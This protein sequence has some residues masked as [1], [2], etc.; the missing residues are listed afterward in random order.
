[1]RS[2]LNELV[3]FG[4]CGDERNLV[5][6]GHAATGLNRAEIENAFARGSTKSAWLEGLH[7]PTFMKAD[8]KILSGPNL[9]YAF[10][11]QTFS[12]SAAISDLGNLGN[13]PVAGKIESFRIGVSYA[14]NTLW[15]GPTNKFEMFADEIRRVIRQLKGPP[16][17]D[18]QALELER[19]EPPRFDLSLFRFPLK[20]YSSS[21][22]CS[23][24]K[25]SFRHSLSRVWS[26]A[27][28][29]I[30]ISCGVFVNEP[31]TERWDSAIARLNLSAARTPDRPRWRIAH[32]R[33]A[34]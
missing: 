22:S 15:T 20:S 21:S 11:D 33:A 13:R 6:V 10:G 7:S 23:S 14:R 31:A 19:P 3:E 28:V 25:Q 34:F 18:T 9:R 29:L 26:S 8:R 5:R 17:A 2:R 16:V 30:C 1:M 32:K 4:V 12:Y 24:S 27:S